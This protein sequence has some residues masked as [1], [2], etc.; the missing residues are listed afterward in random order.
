MNLK[1]LTKTDLINK[2][3][4]MKLKQKEK[5]VRKIEKSKGI[6]VNKTQNSLTIWD[7]LYKLKIYFLSFS[8]IVILSRIFKNY[9]SI[10]AIL[11]LA[12]YVI[13]TLFGFS[14]FEVFGFGF[15]VK[16]LG[17]FKYI[18]G[19]IVDY[20]SDSTFSVY[21]K[22]LFNVMEDE[23]KE[24]IR[25][26]YK[27]K[28][29][30]SWK[31]EIEK[32]KLELEKQKLY[33]RYADERRKE[34]YYE[35]NRKAIF[36]ILAVLSLF[37]AAWY[38]SD[39]IGP[40]AGPLISVFNT[41]KNYIRPN[42]NDGGPDDIT[43]IIFD[44]ENNNNNN[45]HKDLDEVSDGI[46][47]YSADT[48]RPNSP[49]VRFEGLTPQ[50]APAPLPPSDPIFSS[51][52]TI[53]ASSSSSDTIKPSDTIK[54]S[55]SETANT[56]VTPAAPPTPPIPPI[57]VA[58]PAPLA[59][60]APPAPS[61]PPAPPGVTEQ[62]PPAALLD[63]VRLGRKLKKV[64]T[65]F[66]D[67]S[68]RG[69]VA[70]DTSLTGMLS[71]GLDKMRK[72]MA[73]D[74]EDVAQKEED[75]VGQFSKKSIDKDVYSL[76]VEKEENNEIITRVKIDK[77]K[78]KAKFLEAIDLESSR[79]PSPISDSGSVSSTKANLGIS[80][81]IAPVLQQIKENF[82]NISDETLMLLSTPEG[83]KNREAIINNLSE[84]ELVTYA[85]LEKNH[86]VHIEEV[87]E[88]TKN[89]D[90]EEVI[91]KLKEK[92]PGY[93]ISEEGYRESFIKAVEK[94]IAEGK[95]EEEQNKIRQEFIKTD[96]LEL[97][98][99]N[100]C[101]VRSIRNVVRENYTHNNLLKEIKRKSSTISRPIEENPE[102]SYYKN[103]DTDKMDNTMNLFD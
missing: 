33:E 15:I 24:S 94:E 59:P 60:P 6:D 75:W 77:G 2:I 23:N 11:R 43:S 79:A 36:C 65:V 81:K 78:G 37:G 90:S 48:I 85:D 84:H 31:D 18:F 39:S 16:I 1:K 92:F 57:P 54:A 35:D 12:N 61:E 73:D 45:K 46:L 62:G 63:D 27:K 99:L 91:K 66:K 101:D 40:A 97:E 34:Q 64:E 95:T 20:L 67:N 49:A 3:E 53:K 17:E 30:Y 38:F 71:K 4:E 70:E 28:E 74:V 32:R 42:N 98:N 69:K 80:T 103:A 58:P 100:N 56:V 10:R 44:S 72:V 26:I 93:K 29:D 51:S 102:S 68:Y 50:T 88:E 96:L 55:S 9:K 52:D 13:L 47:E 22:K 76:E 25:R 83:L 41:L 87:I 14:M 19:A 21:L 89:L 82:P 5:E 8:L 86:K 7:I